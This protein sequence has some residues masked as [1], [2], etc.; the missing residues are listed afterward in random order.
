[1]QPLSKADLLAAFVNVSKSER[2]AITPPSDLATLDWSNR[3][4]LGWRNAKAP[5]RGYLVAIVDDEPIGALLRASESKMAARISAVCMLYR[6]GRTA[7][8]ISLFTARR[9]GPAGRNGDTVGT[10]I[11]A[12]LACSANVRV[13]KATATLTPDPGLSVE[14][15]IANLITRTGGFLTEVRR[16]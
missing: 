7:S 15:R 16:P 3:E 2:S 13:T 5:L 8:E 9:A 4:L 12:D 10:Y 14:Q 11:C 6:T 1:M